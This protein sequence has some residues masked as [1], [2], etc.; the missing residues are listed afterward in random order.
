MGQRMRDV[1][2][3]Y[4]NDCLRGWDAGKTPKYI[5]LRFSLIVKCPDWD[6]VVY[7]IPPNDRVFKLTQDETHSCLWEVTTTGWHVILDLQ[8]DYPNTIVWLEYMPTGGV[9]FFDVVPLPFDE[10]V[11][12]HNKNLDCEQGRPS[13]SGIAV[14]T[15]TP[16]ATDLLKAINITKGDDLFMELFP[17]DDGKL[18]YKFCRIAESTNIKI[19][20]EP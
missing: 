15:Y 18:V 12:Y 9:Y 5:Y 13:Y 6:E 20:F 1:P 14:L 17:L 19:L 8:F 16:Q 10:G 4:G 7:Q 3:V 2:I 11:V